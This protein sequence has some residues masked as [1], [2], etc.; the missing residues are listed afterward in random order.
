MPRAK[1]P[2]TLEERTKKKLNRSPRIKCEVCKD[3]VNVFYWYSGKSRCKSCL[4]KK[5]KIESRQAFD[6]EYKRA[7]RKH[8]GVD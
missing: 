7:L 6:A 2:T 1:Q 8:M 3:K 5:K 4:A